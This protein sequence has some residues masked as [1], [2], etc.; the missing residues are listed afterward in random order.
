MGP[1]SYEAGACVTCGL[2]YYTCPGHFGHIRLQVPLVHPHLI[3]LLHKILKAGCWH[4]GRL[5]LVGRRK[6][7]LLA[8]LRFE[9]AGDPACGDFVKAYIFAAFDSHEH[10]GRPAPGTTLE[11]QA[12]SLTLG[13]KAT[14]RLLAAAPPA[15]A[16]FLKIV[17]SK[18]QKAVDEAVIG[19]A[20]L[21]WRVAEAAGT[22]LEQ[23]GPGFG[24]AVAEVL[25]FGASNGLCPCCMEK[26]TPMMRGE[27]G[28]FFFGQR[29]RPSAILGPVQLAEQMERMWGNERELMEIIYGLKGRAV[30]RGLPPMDYSMFFV[31]NMLVSPSRCRPA[32]TFGETGMAAENPQN[33][34]YQRMLT[35]MD[36]VVALKVEAETAA[37]AE[38]AGGSPPTKP[39]KAENMRLVSDMQK[40]LLDLYDSPGGDILRN[41]GAMGIRQQLESKQGLFRM[42]MMGKRVNFSCRSVIGPDVFLDTNEVGIPESFAKLLTVAEAVTPL[43]IAQMQAAVL[44]GPDVYPGANAVE[45]W[46]RAGSLQTIKLRSSKNKQQLRTQ[47]KL[48]VRSTVEDRDEDLHGEDDGEVGVGGFSVLPKRVLRHLKTGDIVL[49]N[50]QPTLHRV[51]MM[52]HKVRVLPGDRTIRFHYANCRS[53]NADFD[54]DEMNIHVPQD[55]LARAEARQL[56]LSD[57]HYIAPT[58]G[59]PIRD[60]I[61]DHILAAALISRRGTFFTRDVFAS[62]LY[63]ATE[64]IM[65]GDPLS[66]EKRFSLP[67]PAILKP[68]ALWTGKQLLSAVLDTVRSDRG[69]LSLTGRSRVKADMVGLEEAQVL[70]LNGELL[71]GVLDKNSF[72][73]S[74]FGIV[75]AVQEAY[76]SQA[77]GD[78]LSAVGRLCTL[79]IRRHGHTT[80]VDDLMLLPGAEDT[81]LSRLLEGVRSIGIDT[82]HEVRR[83]FANEDA[84]DGNDVKMSDDDSDNGSANHDE[85]RRLLGELIRSKGDVVEARLDSII[86]TKL[87]ALSST[88]NRCIPSGL[89]KKFPSNGF[90]LMTDTGAKGS[91][92]NSTQI[93]CLLGST[94]MEG[95][96]V[97]RM[98]G[99]GATL[100]CFS[101]YDPS[102]NA[103]GFIASRFLTG[104]TPYE[105]FFHA[106]A[107]REG[108]LDTSLKT[109][110][111]GY[112]QRCLVKHLEGVRLHYDYTVR[113]SNNTVLQLIYGDDGIDPC[114]ASWLMNR[115]PW[116]L[117]NQAA[118]SPDGTRGDGK[119]PR[120]P[121][122]AIRSFQKMARKRGGDFNIMEES[123]PGALAQF[124][125]VSQ[126]FE[127]KISA[128]TSHLEDKKARARVD[129]FL[130]ERYQRAVAEPGEGVGIIAAQSVGEPSTQMTLNTF[131]HAGSESKHVTLGVPRLRE[132]L[133][134]ASKYPK[135]PTMTLPLLDGLSENSARELSQRFANVSLVDLMEKV[136]VKEGGISFRPELGGVAVHNFGIV[137]YF[138]E[139]SVYAKELGFGFGRI[140]TV[141]EEV[142]V[143]KL[144]TQF[145]KELKKLELFARPQAA[146][147]RAEQDTTDETNAGEPGEPT[148]VG[149]ANQDA[150]VEAG[151]SDGGDSDD[152]GDNPGSDMDN[153]AEEDGD[154]EQNSSGEAD[155]DLAERQGQGEVDNTADVAGD[156]DAEDQIRLWKEAK[157]VELTQKK[158]T[159]KKESKRKSKKKAVTVAGK[160]NGDAENLG[161]DAVAADR[162]DEL[163]VGSLGL[164]GDVSA[165]DDGRYIVLPWVLPQEVNGR[166]RVAELVREAAS[167]I[168]LAHV[169]R[170]TRCFTEEISVDGKNCLAVATEGSNLVAALELGYGL[171]DMNR[172]STNDM[173][174]ILDT[175]GVE[176]LR[177]ALIAEFQK[178]FGAY[179]IPVDLR[180]LS[181]IADYQCALG[182]YRA[183]NRISMNSAASTMQQ[184]SFETTMKF[185]TEAALTGRPDT[186]LQAPSASIATGELYSGGTGSFEVLSQI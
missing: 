12:E 91:A 92:V 89:G 94:I 138:P 90:S 86:A 113:D 154:A 28:T 57:R 72:G 80:G 40:C 150:L 184:L 102:P 183:F 44:N 62:L 99:S 25:Q 27:A 122:K 177:A 49:F 167:G 43:N 171:V 8:R 136:A 185:M 20:E 16:S 128:A 84:G 117:S 135:T 18:N 14:A 134:T 162:S 126:L 67:R 73:A 35:T 107:G 160:E 157:R 146:A 137:L 149:T 10:R 65:S 115:L 173:F 83:M 81:R 42:H 7:L 77:A 66:G 47:S 131:H 110:N 174:G 124:G 4:C 145:E 51:S 175:Y 23:P 101:P 11:D 50:R 58:S 114:K 176:A 36:A 139:E 170:I 76:G 69:G 9:H 104:I 121:S 144:Q 48:L 53:Y 75:H 112:L 79:F 41:G 45:D 120:R 52:A 164:T 21:A 168:K 153:Y 178:I 15:L 147:S 37:A 96:R 180:H 181:V 172:V 103:G 156:G 68:R 132:L 24:S 78:F 54:G 88:V 118:L 169:D 6:L 64:R 111:S 129:A 19:A 159:K 151:D 109:A 141:V 39:S 123:S 46:T 71:R 108:L 98:G 60:L 155:E 163:L 87:N 152:K 2:G 106:M 116:Q 85:A 17:D 119:T 161:S 61:Q 33:I 125:I 158:A 56:M 3:G 148:E 59:E 97:P 95:K 105:M 13:R 5:R 186:V 93:S 30:R 166:L 70:F 1:T 34:F 133:M 32:S 140:L 22:L 182:G 179:G 55:D 82:T 142:F 127:E 29:N 130:R 31:R 165:S 38:A 100:P 26:I 74:K 143:E 63:A